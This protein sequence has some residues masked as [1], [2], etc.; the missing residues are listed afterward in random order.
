VVAAHPDRFRRLI[1]ANTFLP[2]CDDAFFAVPAGFYQWKNF[3]HQSKL[4]DYCC[5]IA[6]LLSHYCQV[7]MPL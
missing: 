6:K 3:C 2:T 5:N 1:L 7:V 4:V